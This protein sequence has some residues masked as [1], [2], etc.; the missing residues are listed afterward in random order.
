[1]II[2]VFA[3]QVK[4]VGKIVVC[5]TTGSKKSTQARDF[6]RSSDKLNTSE[7]ENNSDVDDCASSEPEE[8]LRR[9]PSPMKRK[10]TTVDQQRCSDSENTSNKQAVAG[11]KVKK[12]VKDHRFTIETTLT[13]EK[14]PNDW[15]STKYLPIDPPEPE[16]STTKKKKKSTKDC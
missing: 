7:S 3:F 8:E 2:T 1:M 9:Q 12:Q 6:E 16:P 13:V 4:P 5:E 10:K 15:K 11:K 14:R